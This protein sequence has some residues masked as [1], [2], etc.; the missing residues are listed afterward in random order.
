[1]A[2]IPRRKKF[3]LSI[4]DNPDEESRRFRHLRNAWYH[5]RALRFPVDLDSRMMFGAWKIVQCYYTVYASIASLVRCIYHDSERIGHGE[6][7]NKYTDGILT[8]RKFGWF[9]IPPANNFLDQQGNLSNREFLEIW[10][11]AKTYHIPIMKKC[12]E[13]VRKEQNRTT[14]VHYLKNLR[15]WATY[16]DSYLFFRMYAPSVKQNLDGFLQDISFVYLA[17]TELF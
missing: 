15:E 12:L 4:Q 9:F 17:Q 8:S 13:S 3:P 7:I 14:F 11:Y 2:S 1:M 5:E 6:T 10:E 16:E